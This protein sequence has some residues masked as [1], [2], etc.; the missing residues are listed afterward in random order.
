MFACLQ[1]RQHARRAACGV[2]ACCKELVVKS[3]SLQHRAPC[4]AQGDHVHAVVASFLLCR[5]NP[6]TSNPT[7]NRVVTVCACRA[8][9][10][11]CTH[12]DQSYKKVFRTTIGGH[13]FEYTRSCTRATSHH[14]RSSAFGEF[15]RKT[16]LAVISH[17]PCRLSRRPCTDKYAPRTSVVAG[18]SPLSVFTADS[19]HKTTAAVP[20]PSSKMTRNI[21]GAMQIK[22]SRTSQLTERA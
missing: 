21:C 20:L 9:R 10:T 7:I 8:S 4:A 6:R 17:D 11:I 18:S 22:I 2:T 3:P 19:R 15:E 14:H 13:G 16:R 5:N 12:R 1:L